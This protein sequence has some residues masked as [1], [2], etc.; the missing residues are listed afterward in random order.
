MR[1]ELR[2]KDNALRDRDYSGLT[3]KRITPTDIDGFFG[4]WGLIEI[5]KR[6]FVFFEL[7][8]HGELDTTVFDGQRVALERLVDIIPVPAL[9]IY[10]NHNCE[11]DETIDGVNCIVDMHRYKGKW[12]THYR[13]FT[14][15]AVIDKFLTAHGLGHYI[16]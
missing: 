8:H 7:K 15:K 2:N 13:G 14:L 6:V 11:Q 4:V 16:T 3:Y 5:R 9:L 10:A 12:Q 1:G